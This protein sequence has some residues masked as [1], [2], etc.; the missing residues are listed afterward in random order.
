[1]EHLFKQLQHRSPRLFVG[2]RESLRMIPRVL[3]VAPPLVDDK[4]AGA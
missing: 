4:H 2:F 1:M 3:V